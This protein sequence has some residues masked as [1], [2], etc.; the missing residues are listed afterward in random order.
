M[1]RHADTLR[2]YF[3]H[4]GTGLKSRGDSLLGFEIAATRGLFVP[5]EAILDGATVLV[6]STHIDDPKRIRYA[7][8]DDPKATLENREGLPPPPSKPY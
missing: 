2:L 4:T 6:H 8:A 3:D 7:W 5:A 1:T